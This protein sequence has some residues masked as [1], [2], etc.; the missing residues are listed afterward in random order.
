MQKEKKNQNSLTLEEL[1]NYNQGIFLPALEEIFLTKK[2][3]YSFK[4]KT[5]TNQDIMLKKL[6]ILL[7]EK[8]V[9]DYQEEKE[10][11]LWAIVIKALRN[12]RILSSQ[13]LNKIAHLEIF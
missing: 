9:R 7:T 13:E 11:K 1:V 10:K 12:H 6:D 4:D 8:K 3:F 2:E 5:L